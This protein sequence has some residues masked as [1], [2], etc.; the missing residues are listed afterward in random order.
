MS[1][2]RMF[3]F[4]YYDEDPVDPELPEH[5]AGITR[6]D[7]MHLIA[8][9][10]IKASRQRVADILASFASEDGSDVRPS[11]QTVGDMCGGL[12]ENSVSTHVKA[13]VALGMLV[14]K[15]PGGGRSKPTVYRLTRPADLSALPLWLDPEMKRIPVEAAELRAGTPT[16]TQG[17]ESSSNTDSH[18]A[19]S[20][21]TYSPQ[22]TKGVSAET[23]TPT[24]PFTADTPTPTQGYRPVDNSLAA[25]NPTVFDPKPHSFDPQNPETPTPT[26]GDL[27]QADRTTDQ[28]G[29]PQASNSLGQ[30]EADDQPPIS[31]GQFVESPDVQPWTPPAESD[32]APP[33]PVVQAAAVLS[34]VP[35]LAAAL[36]LLEAQPGGGEWFRAAAGRELRAE[37]I[38]H[39]R[40]LDIAL[41]AIVI[42]RRTD[43][44]TRSA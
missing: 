23:P 9:M 24:V 11:L 28:P 35:A 41:R 16:P 7:W 18:A 29:L 36:A 12:H 10:K 5:L 34:P 22:F 31:V 1:G 8:R 15:E 14:V 44:E 38:R 39:P 30:R 32:P 27:L 21:N 43:P 13:L 37:G 17:N 33:S 26:W 6:A 4:R 3:G 2:V 42:L 19:E 25:L 20:S 40:P